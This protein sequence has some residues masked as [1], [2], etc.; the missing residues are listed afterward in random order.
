MKTNYWIFISGIIAL[1]ILILVGCNSQPTTTPQPIVLTPS[2]TP[3][4][5]ALLPT[6]TLISNPTPTEATLLASPPPVSSPSSL[7]ALP[8]LMDTPVPI[9]DEP[10]TPDNVHQIRELAMW[11]KGRIS[12]VVYSPDGRLLAVGTTA[13]IWIYEAKTLSLFRFIE[14]EQWVSALIFAPDS[15]TLDTLLDITTFATWNVNSGQLLHAQKLEPIGQEHLL[16]EAPHVTF[17]ADRTRVAILIPTR[18][19]SDW[20]VGLWDTGSGKLLPSPGKLT[21]EGHINDSVLS[22]DGTL[23]ALISSES[24]WLWDVT[25]GAFVQTMPV[26]S[27]NLAFS[28]DGELLSNGRQLW[29]TEGLK[30]RCALGEAVTVSVTFSP[31]GLLM[32]AGIRGGAIKVWEVETC[33]LRYNLTGHR[34]NIFSLAFSPDS[35]HLA[36]GSRDGTLRQWDSETGASLNT[37]EEYWPAIRDMV[38]TPDGSTIFISPGFNFGAPLLNF[39][40]EIYLRD[41]KTGQGIGVLKGGHTTDAALALSADGKTLV[42]SETNVGETT[43][44]WDVESRQVQRDLGGAA[45]KVALSPDGRKLAV[46][47]SDGKSKC[48]KVFDTQTDE[49]F[50][51]ACGGM[52]I[53]MAFSR[54]GMKLVLVG[55]GEAR[56]FDSQTG[57]QLSLLKNSGYLVGVPVFSPGDQTVATSTNNGIMLWDLDTQKILHRLEAVTNAPFTE[58]DYFATRHLLAFS[59]N[60]QLLASGIS[61]MEA[62]QLAIQPTLRFWDVNKG[63][64]LSIVSGYNSNLSRLFFSPDGKLLI[65]ASLDGT[66]RFLGIPPQ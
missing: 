15:L 58:P 46:A 14:T 54:D 35:T 10:I 64:A 62:P 18:E 8:V 27:G 66:I 42:S 43:L 25:R 32:A 13:G 36:S 38:I 40:R 34:A 23:L 56:V 60:G 49:D 29:E 20:R 9:P 51:T 59:S 12:Q 44:I 50:Y 33:R 19:I 31:N 21:N 30:P 52:G 37:L 11:G 1:T 6:P 45:G 47:G 57:Q 5:V 39:D 2:P 26:S 17:S 7:I 65:T 4:E 28:P 22:P 55:V 16:W 48:V 24:I 3:T 53:E 63:I 61:E 41:V